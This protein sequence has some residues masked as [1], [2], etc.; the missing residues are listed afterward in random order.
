MAGILSIQYNPKKGDIKANLEKVTEIIDQNSDKKLDLVVLPEFFS[1]G[2]IDHDEYLDYTETE[3]SGGHVL[4]WSR[5]M[6]KKYNTNFVSGSLIEKSGKRLYNTSFV[7]DRKGEIVG[8]YRK[9]HLFNYVF[10][11]EGEV[12]TP[13]DKAVVVDLDFGKVGINICYDIRYPMHIKNLAKMGAEIIVCPYAWCVEKWKYNDEKLLKYEED[14]FD[15]LHNVRAYE[16]LVC[17]VSSNQ[18]GFSDDKLY[19]IGHS[20]I[21]EVF[22]RAPDTRMVANAGNKECAI[23]ANVNLNNVRKIRKHYPISTID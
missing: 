22:D 15:C 7:F 2:I 6:A 11:T 20:A 1:T 5:E 13:G 21:Y 18:V 14:I 16:N 17:I 23:Y 9:I 12:I 3:N 19:C 8:K 10:G 4:D